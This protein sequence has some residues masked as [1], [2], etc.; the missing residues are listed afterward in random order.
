[1]FNKFELDIMCIV[2]RQFE[3]QFTRLINRGCLL[4]F[5]N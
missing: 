4:A 3:I 5:V 1:M 2:M